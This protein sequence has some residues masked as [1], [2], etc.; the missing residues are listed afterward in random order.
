VVVI[1]SERAK[2]LLQIPRA[3]DQTNLSQM[4][5]YPSDDFILWV[6]LERDQQNVKNLSFAGTLQDHEKV[7]LEA[8][9]VLMKGRPMTLLENLSLRECEAFLRDRNSELAL[10][11]LGAE[12]ESKFKKLF[13]WLRAFRPA[14]APSEYHFSSQTGP[15]RNLKLIDKVRELKAFLN[16]FEI[17][18]LY[19]G[20]HSPE[21]ID[22]DDLTVFIQAPYQSEKDKALFEELHI[23]G[24]STFQEDNLNFIPEA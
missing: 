17:Q 23:L 16:S 12:E 22:V 2:G 20:S 10:E 14:E 13:L 7:L 15:F 5:K 11:N 8:L 6:N 1:K 18:E 21:L 19:Q 4:R 24:V 9:A 3:I